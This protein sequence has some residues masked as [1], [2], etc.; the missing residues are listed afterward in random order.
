MKSAPR[1]TVEMV[2]IE[3][4]GDEDGDED[5]GEDGKGDF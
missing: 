5:S 4:D 1:V 3:R 2:S